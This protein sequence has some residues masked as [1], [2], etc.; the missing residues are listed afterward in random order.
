[1]QISHLKFIV[2]A[3]IF[4]LLGCAS[5]PS[6]ELFSWRYPKADAHFIKELILREGYIAWGEERVH[7]KDY[8][9]FVD[10]YTLNR[11]VRKDIDAK[12]NTPL[13]ILFSFKETTPP[14]DYYRNLA[15]NI[16]ASRP[17]DSPEIKTEIER[18]ESMLYAKLLEIA[19]N[20]N[21]VRGKRQKTEPAE[22]KLHPVGGPPAR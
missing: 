18:M 3:A 14:S 22:W 12:K 15:I 20:A 17:V 11:Y 1:M 9:T 13:T 2:L 7:C 21:V 6:K 8:G 10:C 4:C 19:G 16:G 5:P